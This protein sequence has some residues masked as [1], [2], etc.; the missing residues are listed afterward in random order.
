MTKRL[1]TGA[2]A[3]VVLV[4][5]CAG[6]FAQ[7]SEKPTIYAYV[8]WWDVPREKWSAFVEQ[9]EKYELP[10]NDRLVD[11]GVL[12]EYGIDSSGLHSP[13]GY[14]HST[15]LVATSLGNIERA[16][17]SYYE[18]LGADASRLEAE[19]GGMVLKHMDFTVK[20]D[21]YGSRATKLSK[22]YFNSSSIR[23]KLGKGS[24]YVKLWESSVM[25]VFDQLLADGTI[26]AY[27]LDT[28]VHHT[29]EQSLGATTSWYVLE[30]MDA[31]AKVDAA[32]D[33]ARE[34]L[35]ETERKARTELYW[36]LVV[37]DS[38]RDD[39]TRLIHYRTK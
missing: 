24:D 21:H 26:V 14:T 6:G 8:G 28:P 34:K 39:F 12:I 18:S 15:W 37:E 7:G 5:L 3:S 13:D 4:L 19:L 35:T 25:P 16:M 23:V 33:A 1:L 32:F 31:D 22:G 38:H 17:D 11:Q 30:N 29:S 10:V 9:Y 2:F 27:G 20:S 36:S